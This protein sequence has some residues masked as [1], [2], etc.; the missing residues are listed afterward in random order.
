MVHFVATW[1]PAS[2]LRPQECGG[3]E[4]GGCGKRS[5][6][7]MS[8]AECARVAVEL[9]GC[10][11]TFE[12]AG[13]EEV[14]RLGW[15]GPRSQNPPGDVGSVGGRVA[16]GLIG[17]SRRAGHAHVAPLGVVTDAWLVRTPGGGGWVGECSFSL[18]SDAAHVL[19]AKLGPRCGGLG[20]VSLTTTADGCRP[21]E[22]TLCREP[23]RAG[24]LITSPRGLCAGEL[25]VYKA[26]RLRWPHDY[27]TAMPSPPSVETPA[28]APTATIVEPSPVGGGTPSV[29]EAWSAMEPGARAVLA[30]QL[31]KMLGDVKSARAGRDA[32]VGRCSELEGQLTLANANKKTDMALLERQLEILAAQM[33]DEIRDQYALSDVA[34]TMADFRSG[35]HHAAIDAALRTVLC[36]SRAMQMR[37][38]AGPSPKRLRPREAAP[39]PL[40]VESAGAVPAAAVVPAAVDETAVL[41]EALSFTFDN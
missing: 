13:I 39:S 29:E 14:H 35:S 1:C 32:A 31:Q 7:D 27:P 15:A 17:L 33:P 18:T 20:A 23:A 40:R 12:H 21:L 30:G 41:R 24:A 2:Y 6:Y 26:C 37:G 38:G 25:A 5:V 8:W 16:A 22:L 9:A 11:V 28:A 4:G 19:V 3:G 36:A 10:P 34:A